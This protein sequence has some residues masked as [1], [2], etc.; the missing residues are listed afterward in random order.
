MVDSG[1][2]AIL[3]RRDQPG[4]EMHIISS[5]VRYELKRVNYTKWHYEWIP[6]PQ[7]FRF[8]S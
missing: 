5:L 8:T 3:F 4:K 6:Y 2:C 1:A 7:H